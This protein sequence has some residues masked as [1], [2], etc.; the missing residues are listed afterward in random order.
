MKKSRS[1]RWKRALKLLYIKIV[2]DKG[3][4]DYI[5]RGWALGLFVGCVVP[6]FCQLI[7]S[8]PLSF[9]FRCSKVGAVGGTFITTP[10]TAIFIYP[11]QCFIGSWLLA[12]PIS[13]QEMRTATAQMTQNAD[14]SSFIAMG[15]KVI[16]AF[17][18]GGLL[19]AAIMTPV[20]YFGVKKMVISYRRFK[21]ER[22]KNKMAVK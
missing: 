20:T 21:Q 6:V 12:S 1:Q 5:A 7:V 10:P 8:V 19:W 3:T 17:F 4:P 11:V 18:A 2:R 15:G 14:Y 16:S 9:V 22:L 13:L